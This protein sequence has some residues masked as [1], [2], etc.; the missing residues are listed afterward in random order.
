[1][2]ILLVTPFF[3]PQ[4]VIAV[5]R[6]GQWTKYLSRLGHDVTV[7]TTKKYPFWPLDYKV[8][9]PANVKIVEVDYL[10]SIV[11]KILGFSSP[12]KLN[13]VARDGPISALNSFLGKI[14]SKITHYFDP[15]DLWIMPASKIGLALAEESKF[16]MIVSSYSPA[17]A[18]HVARNIKLKNS[19]S[20]WIADFRDLWAKNHLSSRGYLGKTIENIREKFCIQHADV[21]ITISKP[22]AVVLQDSY[23]SKKVEVI[24]NGYDPEDYPELV[25]LNDKKFSPSS[26]V[27]ISYTGMIYEG[28]RDPSPLLIAVNELIDSGEI[29]K[30]E[31]IV[32]FY[33]PSKNVLHKIIHLGDFNRHKFIN[34]FDQV[35]RKASIDIQKKSD[36]LLLLEWSD[37]SSRGVLTGKLFEYLVSGRPILGV[38]VHPE[39]EAG[40]LICKAQAGL[41]SSDVDVIKKLLRQYIETRKFQSFQPSIK[42]IKRYSR[43][44]Q[45]LN[46]IEIF[47]NYN[48]D[49]A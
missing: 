20:V 37:V 15:H 34:V 1:M 28:K 5:S 35:G 45:V 42:E 10:P 41:V 36:I 31:C 7:L 2:K 48:N 12:Q 40:L 27:I 16:D 43:D 3:Y 26:Q 49:Q 9:L 23:P 25:M 4:N 38:G 47:V 6:V 46:L 8:E 30:D 39:S 22:L 33:G 11:K 29:K 21:L 32:N 24:A 14:K 17:A 13:S 44:Q 19:N 18:H